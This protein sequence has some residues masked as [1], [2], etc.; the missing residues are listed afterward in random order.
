MQARCLLWTCGGY[1]L[2]IGEGGRPHA[3]FNAGPCRCKCGVQLIPFGRREGGRV[4]GQLANKRKMAATGLADL[5]PAGRARL[6]VGPQAVFAA[7]SG[8]KLATGSTAL[9]AMQNL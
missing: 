7:F 4:G 8:V 5:D 2:P 3:G 1:G 6:A 9:Q